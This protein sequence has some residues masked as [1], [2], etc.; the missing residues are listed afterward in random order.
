MSSVNHHID[1]YMYSISLHSH[2]SNIAQLVSVHC[3]R[4]LCVL[5]LCH[6]HIVCFAAGSYTI[7]SFDLLA[8]SSPSNKLTAMYVYVATA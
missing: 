2:F 4:I 7:Q 1:I 3:S 5:L 8:I 6:V